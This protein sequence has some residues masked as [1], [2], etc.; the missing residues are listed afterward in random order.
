ML[1]FKRYSKLV[2]TWLDVAFVVTGVCCKV[3]VP[4]RVCDSSSLILPLLN[5]SVPLRAREFPFLLTR[6]GEAG[7]VYED[8]VVSL[9][10]EW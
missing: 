2:E 5:G 7:T 4:P 9:E 3:F 1:L 6:F 8:F 10:L